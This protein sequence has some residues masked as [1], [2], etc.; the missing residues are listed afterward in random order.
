MNGVRRRLLGALATWIVVLAI[1]AVAVHPERCGTARLDE[2]RNA[3]TAAVGWFQANVEPSGR[4]VYRYDKDANEYL[5][6][7]NDARHAGA[8][9]S[10]YQAEFAGIS[11]AAEIADSALKYVDHNV[12]LT[13]AG[14]AFGRGQRFELGATALLVAALAERRRALGDTTRDVDLRSLGETLLASIDH[15]GVVQSVVDRD[16]GLIAESRSPFTTGQVMFALAELELIYP[17]DGFGEGARA[18]LDYVIVDRDDEEDLF[19]MLSDH[20]S[21]YALVAM[22]QWPSPPALEGPAVGW[23]ERQLGLFGVQVR[24]ESQRVGGITRLTRGTIALPAGVGTVGEGLGNLSRIVDSEALD[25]DASALADRRV[26]L[27]SLLIDRQSVA[28]AE[29]AHPEAVHGAWFRLGVTQVDD[30]QHPLSALLLLEAYL[31]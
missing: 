3:A 12:V 16:D 22:S 5:G 30:Q 19:P 23:L 14:P 9:F 1:V 18:I 20:W 28:S 31:R 29:D 24:Y 13:T 25:V 10:L 2:A 6:G 17:S 4:F 21:T 27:A 11:G 26:C 8:L 15:G 7:Y